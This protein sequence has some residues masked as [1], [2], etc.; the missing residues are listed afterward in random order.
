MPSVSLASIA[1]RSPAVAGTLVVVMAVFLSSAVFLLLTTLR[2]DR[3][4][5]VN[6][7]SNGGAAA[8][9][10]WCYGCGCAAASPANRPASRWPCP[11]AT[12]PAR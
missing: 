3:W 1:V 9:L 11:P 2:D 12:G 6:A 10:T 7:A 4:P 8:I 5:T